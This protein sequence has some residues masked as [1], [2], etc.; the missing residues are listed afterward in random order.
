MKKWSFYTSKEI[1]PEGWLRRQLEIQAEG[2]S[3]NLH[4]IWP[5]IRDSGWI[6]GK[7]EGYRVKGDYILT[8]NDIDEKRIHEDATACLTWSIDMHFPEPSNQGIFGEAFRSFAYHR[9]IEKPYPVPDRCLYSK[10]VRNLFLG[11]RLVSASH[12]AF[13]SV[14]VMRTLG[15]LGEVVGM[16]SSVC[17]KHGCSPREVYTE[18]LDEFKALLN[19]GIHFPDAF[20]CAVESEEAYHFKDIGWWYLNT[21]KSDSPESIEKFKKGVEALG[22]E[23]KYPMPEKWNKK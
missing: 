1:K 13:S 11:G 21:A 16:A 7:R 5:D 6:G 3:G 23:H 2:L 4:K 20:E 19:A 8:Q 22:L 15:E 10:D 17:K 12:V 14:R 18:H 9:G